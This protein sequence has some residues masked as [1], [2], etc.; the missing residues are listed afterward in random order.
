MVLLIKNNLVAKYLF[1]S[2]I[3]FWSPN[4]SLS[5]FNFFSY[6]LNC[7]KYLKETFVNQKNIKYAILDYNTVCFHFKQN[8]AQKQIKHAASFKI[9]ATILFKIVISFKI[10]NIYFIQ[11]QKGVGSTLPGYYSFQKDTL[12][13]EYHLSIEICI[14]MIL[15]FL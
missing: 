7:L 4:D 15:C 3:F 10:N 9:S 1:G 12:S 5:L 8:S 13:K 14:N 2:F 6:I 11:K